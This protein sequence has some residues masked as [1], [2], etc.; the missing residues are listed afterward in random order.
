MGSSLASH[1][2]SSNVLRGHSHSG[3][4]A[5]VEHSSPSPVDLSPL[6]ERRWR[7]LQSSEALH[8]LRQISIISLFPRSLLLLAAIGLLPTADR[9]SAVLVDKHWKEATHGSRDHIALF[10]VPASLS[11]PDLSLPHPTL[12][13][14]GLRQCFQG[15]GRDRH[16]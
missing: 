14:D 16:P 2:D 6:W 7:R 10:I 4:S 11:T 3:A 8:L 9:L 1:R 12:D 13:N 15:A 5:D